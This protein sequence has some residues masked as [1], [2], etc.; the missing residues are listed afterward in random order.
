MDPV[1]LRQRIRYIVE[2]G[3]IFPSAR[4]RHQGVLLLIAL[5]VAL[6]DAIMLAQLL[7]T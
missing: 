5:L 6:G 4:G 1:L 3:E 2:F 7:P